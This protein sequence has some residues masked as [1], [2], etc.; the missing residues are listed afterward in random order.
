MGYC[1]KTVNYCFNLC[2]LLRDLQ[3]AGNSENVYALSLN[4]IKMIQLKIIT[5]I[6]F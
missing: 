2:F 4:N 5:L 1:M 3:N 6:Y